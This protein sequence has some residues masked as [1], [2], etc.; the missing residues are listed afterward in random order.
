ME[1][2]DLEGFSSKARDHARNPRNYGSL[3][4]FNGFARITGPCGDTMAFWLRVRDGLVERASFET[5]G[6]GSS[7]ACGSK[8][9]CLAEGRRVEE[10]AALQQRDILA[11]LGGMPG[12]VEH[13]ALLAA[14]TLKAAC[15]DYLKE[16]QINWNISN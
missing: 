13:C 12:E 16:P 1:C 2:T 14:N 9:A 4:N 15:E 11:A 6:C 8:A 7:R 3:T 10:A 5:D